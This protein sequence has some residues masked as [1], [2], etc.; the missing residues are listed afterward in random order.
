MGRQ[1]RGS[2]PHEW[3]RGGG[4]QWGVP[5]ILQNMNSLSDGYFLNGKSVWFTRGGLTLGA[6]LPQPC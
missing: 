1:E 4:S 5:C 3:G 6:G 2:S